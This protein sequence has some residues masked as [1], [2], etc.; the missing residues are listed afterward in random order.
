MNRTQTHTRY[1]TLILGTIILTLTLTSIP[2]HA[3]TT[4]RQTIITTGTSIQHAIDT[5]TPGDLLLINPGTYT[6]PLTITTPLTLQ[7]TTP[8]TVHIIPTTTCY[9]TITITA[10][11]VTLNGL[12]IQNPSPNRY[13]TAVSLCAP[14]TTIT[15]CHFQNTSLGIACWAPNTTITTSTFTNCHD[16]GIALLG[17]PDTPLTHILI[18]DCTF[19]QNCDGIELQCTSHTQIHH[20][21]FTN[22]THAGIDAIN[23]DNNNNHITNCQFTANQLGIYL[24]NAANTQITSSTFT[25]SPAYFTHATDNDLTNCNLDHLTLQDR[26]TLTLRLCQAIDP[27]HITQIDSTLTTHASRKTYQSIDSTLN[28]AYTTLLT[29]LTTV[30]H[31]L[32]S[33]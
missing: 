15:T 3:T 23:T 28:Q 25:T 27:S 12:T 5:A 21:T 33:A 29:R 9:Y 32:T 10:P 24:A 4:T 13:A 16:E 26:T 19:T 8:D 31:S 17:I 1:T 14:H 30:Y 11:H 6:E 2:T 22:N 18:T 7:A 20:C